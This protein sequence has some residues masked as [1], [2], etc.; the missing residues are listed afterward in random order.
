M[1]N[2][3]KSI[4]LW[5]LFSY[6][7]ILMKTKFQKFIDEYVFEEEY[8]EEISYVTEVNLNESAIK[9]IKNDLKVHLLAFENYKEI[10]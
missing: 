9:K 1:I 4:Y 2:E 7:A 8:S 5:Y 6:G 10:F 3:K